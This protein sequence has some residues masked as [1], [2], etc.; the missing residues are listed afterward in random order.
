MQTESAVATSL[1]QF[2]VAKG[3]RAGQDFD[4]NREARLAF[5]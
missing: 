3:P 5:D 2:R 1:K 4:E